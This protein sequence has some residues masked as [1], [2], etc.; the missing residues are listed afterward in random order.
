MLTI[1][2]DGPSGAGKSTL[3]RSLAQ[4]LG[5]LYLDTG[6]MYRAIGLSMLQR[7]IDPGD[8]QA[9]ARALDGLDVAVRLQNGQ[10]DTLV[11][12]V[13]VTELLRTPQVSMA[14]S[15]VSAHAK[16]RERMVALQRQIAKGQQIV[17]DGRDIGTNVL[18]QAPY[19]FFITA[20]AQERA[21][22]RC[23]QL[24]AAGESVVYLDVL[25][26]VQRRDEQDST[27]ALNPLRAA[28]DAVVIWT[29]QLDAQG[30]LNQVLA[31]IREKQE[32]SCCTESS[33]S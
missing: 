6:A 7:G 26:D 15:L 9:V 8:E 29:D 4:S 10:Q 20:T 22:R 27:R 1:A 30:V 3:A 18:P 23:E 31:F 32:A 14:A 33:I 13:S 12:G 5:I 21:R 25:A 17:L 19:K 2:I 28:P 11:D 24:R 16:V